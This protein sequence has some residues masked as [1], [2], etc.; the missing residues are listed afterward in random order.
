MKPIDR[1]LLGY[2]RS[3]WPW[4]WA[5]AIIGILGAALMV[6]Q[7]W[8]LARLLV[9]PEVGWT[10]TMLAIV[11]VGRAAL[12]WLTDVAAARAAS[13]AKATLRSRLLHAAFDR[14]PGWLSRRRTG[15]ISTLATRGV[16]AL[17]GYCGR[18]LPAVITAGTIPPLALLVIGVA[19]RSAALVALVGLPLIP[20]FGALV[21][22]ATE[23]RARRSW[24][25][26]ST[27]AGHFSDVVAGLP[28]LLVFRRARAQQRSIAEA[29]DGYRRANAATLRLAF[30][31]GAVLELVAT[32]SVALVAVSVGLRVAHGTF[33]LETALL[34][35]LLIPEVY[36]P[37]RRVGAEFHAA[38][39]G[40]AAFDE[41]AAIAP[42][43]THLVLRSRGESMPI[44]A[45][46]QH[47]MS[48][49]AGAAAQDRPP[50]VEFG[51]LSVAGRLAPW[52]ARW[53]S[54][55]LIGLVGPSGAGKST[56]FDV[57]LRFAEPTSGRVWIDGVDLSTLDANDWRRRVA[58]LPQRPW[59]AARS[60]AENVRLAAP[61][62][63]RSQIMTALRDAGASDVAERQLDARGHGLSLGQ[64]QRVALARL[65]L[66]CATTP[67]LLVLCDEPTAYVD[68]ETERTVTDAMEQLARRHTVVIV[69]HR[70][71]PL[72]HADQIVRVP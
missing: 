26:L 62:A 12:V 33:E 21:G 17:D 5:V 34:I 69:S 38:S 2:V 42:P 20:L 60:V 58:W 55:E 70:A 53:D 9:R 47:R 50:Q 19:D 11:V 52:S 37:L 13:V 35:L 6:T 72:A 18:Y 41:I 46:T 68:P 32:I 10:L 7:A 59:L 28:T 16:E 43:R 66:R 39:E 22:W 30:L 56:V 63:S 54:G 51:A 71:A 61:T 65:L 48:N 25:A 29:T 3:A 67:W 36:L 14:W 27:L 40:L 4:I 24:R 8:L 64:Q 45:E 31:S 44:S 57:L 23:R 49:W 1:R 15:E